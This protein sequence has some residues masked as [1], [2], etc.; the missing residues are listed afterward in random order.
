MFLIES[1]ENWKRCKAKWL[2]RH[3]LLMACEQGNINFTVCL[4]RRKAKIGQTD[5][6][7]NTPLHIASQNGHLEIV[8]VLVEKGADVK[9]K[10]DF[11]KT[12]LH[13]ASQN[14]HLKIVQVLLDNGADFEAKT[15]RGETPLDLASQRSQSQVVQILKD[16]A[17]SKSNAKAGSPS[18][19]QFKTPEDG[20]VTLS[21]GEGKLESR[22]G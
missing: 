3:V 18:V 16:F 2:P 19:L 5:C 7:K 6:F 22:K 8:Q 9:A 13:I 20:P 14:G 4:I 15:N 11:C 12:P 17:A 1:G 21:A 10:D